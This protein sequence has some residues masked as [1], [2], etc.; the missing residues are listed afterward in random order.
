MANHEKNIREYIKN[1]RRETVEKLM[2]LGKIPAPSGE[3]DKRAQYCLSWFKE[4]GAENAF[5]DKA[6]NAVCPLD[7]EGAESITVFMAHM[8]VVFPDR[9]ELPMRREGN[10]LSAPGIGDDTANLVNLMMGA[11]YLIE[12]NITLKKGIL[13]VANAGEEGLGNLKGCRR[14]FEDYGERIDEFYS[15][16]GYMP[17]LIT[18]PVGSHRYRITL[19]AE[20]GHSYRD[21]GREN[22]IAALASLIGELY[23]IEPPAGE[24]TTY[25]VGRIEGG[26][27]VNSLPQEATALYEYRSSSQECLE[28]MEKQFRKVIDGFR[29]GG[30]SVETEL[31][32]IRP[33]RGLMNEKAFK[34]W[35]EGNRKVIGKHYPG[36]IR[37]E[38]QSTDANIPLSRGIPA[39]TI[40]TVRGDGAHTREEWVDL[41]SLTAGQAIVIDLL[42][43]AAV[44]K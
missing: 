37:Q 6:K 7:C 15:F 28:I 5:I 3:E 19:R 31:L 33:G 35:A 26:T 40:G 30:H 10:I 24:K 1:N 36:E 34:I 20:G 38:A 2:E 9:E 16:D 14:I 32:G 44:G 43:R 18:V 22:A 41:E 39:G 42:V 11:R 8:D 27:T 29:A 13:I 25:N 4:M 23:R 21:F 12:E 17:S